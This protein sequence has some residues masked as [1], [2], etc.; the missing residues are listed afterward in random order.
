MV[1][2]GS[3]FQQ[4]AINRYKQQSYSASAIAAKASSYPARRALPVLL[5]G[6]AG[7]GGVAGV[8]RGVREAGIV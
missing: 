2:F 5:A 7:T 6:L 1:L 8:G 4:A 3:P